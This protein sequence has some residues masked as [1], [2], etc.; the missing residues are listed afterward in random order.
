MRWKMGATTPAVSWS[1]N[2]DGAGRTSSGLTRPPRAYRRGSSKVGADRGGFC[3]YQW[4]ENLIG[5]QSAPP[6]QS[7]RTGPREK[8]GNRASTRMRRRRAS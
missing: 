3:S 1:G 8:A 2:R 5:C 4:L 6:R 7:T